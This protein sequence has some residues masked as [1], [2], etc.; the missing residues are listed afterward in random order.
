MRN[1]LRIPRML[2]SRE[3]FETWAVI[4]CDQFTADRE[5][6]KRVEESVGDAPS[7][8]NFILPEAYLGED[9][10]TRVKTIC[11][12]MYAAL[13]SDAL[14]KLNR[15][16]IFTERT[17]RTGVR[18][19]IMVCIDLEAFSCDPGV[20]ASI[21]SSEAVIPG[22]LPQ[23]VALRRGMPLEFPHAMI[24]YRD[25]KNR[26]VRSLLHEELECVYDFDL[27]AG[28]GHITGRFVPE[29]LAAEILPLLYGRG[30]PLFAV[31][32]GNHAVAAAK[33]YWEEVK[34]ALRGEEARN[35]PARFMLAEL[36][37]VYD[38]AVVLYPIHRLVREVDRAA[39]FDFFAREV[40][41]ERRENVLYVTLPAG[42]AAV[43]AAD[44]AAERFVR[45]NGGKID[46]IHG[47]KELIRCA[48]AEDCAGIALRPI[49]KDD[50][51]AG[52]KGG[53]NFP[54]KMFSVGEGK[55]K[56]YYLEG[57]EI[58]YD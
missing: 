10:E 11:E 1:C 22:R 12:S 15:G 49:D 27:M 28:G 24:F 5:Y 40:P 17:T 29:D 37:N 42:A 3:G 18:R 6:W 36:I 31:A 41:C 43:A 50:F 19:G 56:R 57:R 26:A 13:E 2:L 45:A 23:R 52:L 14:A 44:A 30:E 58:S 4:A 9:D 34:P 47:E 39:F 53:V 32:D 8:L 7:T 46:Y 25:K 33:A 38:P 16:V 55:D 48:A 54:K 20:Q 51:F 21:R 35:H